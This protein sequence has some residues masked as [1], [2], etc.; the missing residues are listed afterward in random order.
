LCFNK[1]KLLIIVAIDRAASMIV[2]AAN[3]NDKSSNI[4]L[5]A[6]SDIAC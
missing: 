6:R 2:K 4:A 1:D 3:A 5:K